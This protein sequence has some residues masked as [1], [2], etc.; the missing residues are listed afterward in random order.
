[1]ASQTS[2]QTTTPPTRTRDFPRL[3]DL[4]R[5]VRTMIYK[6][7]LTIRRNIRIRTADTVGRSALLGKDSRSLERLEIAA[8]VAKQS[9]INF[10]LLFTSRRIYKEAIPVLYGCNIFRFYYD[11]GDI[12]CCRFLKRLTDLGRNSVRYLEFI[13]RE[14]ELDES[15]WPFISKLKSLP[16]LIYSDLPCPEDVPNE[17]EDSQ[18][19][20]GSQR[21]KWITMSFLNGS[22]LMRIDVPISCSVWEYLSKVKM[23]PKF[24]HTTFPSREDVERSIDEPGFGYLNGRANMISIGLGSRHFSPRVEVRRMPGYSLIWRQESLGPELPPQMHSRC[25]VPEATTIKT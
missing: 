25:R 14:S 23:H 15:T 18:Q 7:C 16:N 21:A 8:C 1:M 12:T 24:A 9:Y 11:N 10:N 2:I 20:N 3:F 22:W 19:T 13:R 6:E 4:P 5:E 17:R